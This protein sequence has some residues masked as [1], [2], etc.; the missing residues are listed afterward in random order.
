VDVAWDQS[1]STD[2]Q[3]YKVY[4]SQIS[5]GPY[6]LI[7]GTLS[8]STLQFTDS[9]VLSGQTYFYVVTS[10]DTN[11]LESVHSTEV[12]AQIPN[13]AALASPGGMA[14][15]RAWNRGR[16]SGNGPSFI[17]KLSAPSDRASDL[18]RSLPEVQ[19]SSP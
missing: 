4:R 17:A 9:S 5:G 8:A 7:S 14:Q 19:A 16:S 18:P 10:I 1:S 12:N 2:V 13:T 11:G 15:V 6:T 3:G